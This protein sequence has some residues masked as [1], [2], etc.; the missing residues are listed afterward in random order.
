[1]AKQQKKNYSIVTQQAFT[2]TSSTTETLIKVID[3]VTVSVL[4]AFN[5]FCTFFYRLLLLTPGEC[6]LDNY[7]NV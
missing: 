4:L 7:G 5:I 6:L 2:S 3:V 1:M